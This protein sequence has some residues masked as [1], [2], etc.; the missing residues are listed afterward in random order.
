MSHG[1]SE[2]RIPSRPALPVSPGKGPFRGAQPIILSFDE[3]GTVFGLRQ[4]PEHMDLLRGHVAL[5]QQEGITTIR[6]P[7]KIEHD[8]GMTWTSPLDEYIAD[9]HRQMAGRTQFPAQAERIGVGED[10]TQIG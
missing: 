8:D 1:H 6:H 4:V 10:C 9:G 2:D 5:G 7:G 3:P